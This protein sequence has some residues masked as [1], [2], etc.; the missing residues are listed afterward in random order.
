[1]GSGDV[2][3]GL[4]GGA[5][6]NRRLWQQAAVVCATLLGATA[7]F[8]SGTA[9]ALENPGPEQLLAAGVSAQDLR[10]AGMSPQ[11]WWDESPEFDGRLEPG[12]S[13]ELITFIVRATAGPPDSDPSL[14]ETAVALFPRPEASAADFARRAA[15]DREYGDFENGPKVGNESRYMRRAA[16][17]DPRANASVRVRYGRYLFRIDA[18]G[19]AAG[20]NPPILASLAQRVVE[21]L[22]KLDEGKLAPAPLP[23]ISERLPSADSE[24]GP[25]MGT[26]P[27]G[28]EAWGWVWSSRNAHYAISPRLSTLAR[29]AAGETGVMR[30]YA[31]PQ[32]P[33]EVVEVTIM[34]FRN[35]ETATA[36]ARA[37][38]EEDPVR[39]AVQSLDGQWTVA[40]PIPS[41]VWAYQIAS[42][43][44]RYVFQIICG[45][46]YGATGPE[47]EQV[48][49]DMADRA[50]SRLVE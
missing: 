48:A 6:R 23:K 17:K 32:H 34:P 19:R 42:R 7:C 33:D 46:P 4:S 15:T 1:M 25:V 21:R 5:G 38:H 27:L 9:A 44:G 29:D 40:P 49:R 13:P 18:S 20:V 28:R 43:S 24:F 16:G 50:A 36:F 47:C 2:I 39:G 45:S 35:A 41:A 37:S 11:G 26:A 30:R 22:Q 3:L 8:G 31:L 10:D 12:V 14:V